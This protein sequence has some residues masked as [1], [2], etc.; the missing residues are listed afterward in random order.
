MLL[1]YVK[2]MYCLQRL[3]SPCLPPVRNAARSPRGEL[4][5]HGPGAR[6]ELR[7][8]AS[9][10]HVASHRRQQRVV[11][12]GVRLQERPGRVAHAR[13]AV[14]APDVRGAVCVV[15]TLRVRVHDLVRGRVVEVDPD[16]VQEFSFFRVFS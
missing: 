14:A 2:S 4:R 11:R 7:D 3:L 9:V 16:A 5:L 10:R 13:V 12:L 8:G 1:V 6:V 15:P